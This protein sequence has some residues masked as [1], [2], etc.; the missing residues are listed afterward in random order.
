MPHSPTQTPQARTS[1]SGGRCSAVRAW[2]RYDL[3]H[4]TRFRYQRFELSV[5]NTSGTWPVISNVA[6]L[7]QRFTLVLVRERP[8][9]A[10]VFARRRT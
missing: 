10:S 5:R 9:L 8:F 2:G 6:N 3:T 4:E 1:P 7:P